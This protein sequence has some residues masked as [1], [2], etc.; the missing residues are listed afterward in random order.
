ML[1]ESKE[2]VESLTPRLRILEVH[3]LESRPGK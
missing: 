2:V 1:M 3:D